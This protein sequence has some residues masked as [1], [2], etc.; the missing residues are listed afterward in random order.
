M[1][2]IIIP[3]WMVWCVLVYAIL[4]F[5]LS[6]WSNILKEQLQKQKKRLANQLKLEK[7]IQEVLK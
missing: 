5:A 6:V 4:N 2:G 3:E 7:E 1:V